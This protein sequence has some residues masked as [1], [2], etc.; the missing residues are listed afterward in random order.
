MNCGIRRNA[1]WLLVLLFGLNAFSIYSASV[2]P[3][4][5]SDQGK[6]T[7]ENPLDNNNNFFIRT[8]EEE[9]TVSRLQEGF[10]A[11]ATPHTDSPICKSLKVPISFKEYQLELTNRFYIKYGKLLI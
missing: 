1:F 5:H 9:S 4:C 2:Q 3:F 10:P 8:S 11:I 6:I 7:Y